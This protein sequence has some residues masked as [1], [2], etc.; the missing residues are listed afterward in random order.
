MAV[1]AEDHATAAGHPFAHV[2]VDHRLMGWNV[3]PAVLPGRREPESVVVLVD[4]AA[5]STQGVVAVGEDVGQRKLAHAGGPC[6]LDDAHIGDVVRRDR[7]EPD[8]EH[9]ASGIG[10]VG[11]HDSRRDGPATGLRDPPSNVFTRETTGRGHGPDNRFVIGGTFHLDKILAVDEKHLAALR[12]SYHVHLAFA[13]GVRCSFN[14]K[15]G[16][17]RELGGAVNICCLQLFQLWQ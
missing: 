3:D 15:D 4:G 5:Y 2:L 6:R 1:G 12:Y 13:A 9:P 14:D 7:V 10:G 17:I 16:S 11:P 8:M